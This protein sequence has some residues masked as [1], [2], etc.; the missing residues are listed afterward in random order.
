VLDPPNGEFFTSGNVE[1]GVDSTGLE[2]GDYT[3]TVSFSVEGHPGPPATVNVSLSV[4]PA[5]LGGQTPSLSTAG[6]V[7]SANFG[8]QA[9]APGGLFTIFGSNLATTTAQASGAPLPTNLG[10][11]EVVVNGRLAPLL[12]VSPGQINAQ[13]PADAEFGRGGVIVRTNL[14]QTLTIFMESSEAAPQLFTE[15]GRAIAINQDGTLNSAVNAARGGQF[16][17]VFLTGQ[18]PVDPPVASGLAAPGNPLAQ[19]TL[20]VVAEIGGRQVEVQFLGLA[21]GFVGLGQANLMVPTGLSGNLNV[22]LTIGGVVSNTG[23]ITVVE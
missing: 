22:R 6:I 8:A 18:G 1:V 5:G 15:G 17:T 10:G 7:S 12:Y 9:M 4:Q 3:A 2:V 23:V 16:V 11:T 20:P 21:P 19:V 13:F 14:G